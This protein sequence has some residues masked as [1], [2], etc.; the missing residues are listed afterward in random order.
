MAITTFGPDTSDLTLRTGV[1]GRAAR[2]GHRLTIGFTDWS[3]TVDVDAPSQVAV[4]VAVGSLEVRGGEGGL[5]PMTAPERLVARANALKS[6]K[7]DK[8]PEIVFSA[9]SATPDGDGYRFDGTLTIA[10]TSRDHSV[11]VVRDGDRAIGSS[12]IGHGDFGLKPYALMMGA[13]K[14]A[15]DVEVEWSLAL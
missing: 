14:V 10:G 1:T 8:Y 11:R 15:D 3:A 13:L 5:T 2:T 7:A 12:R 4:R 6:L 9:Q